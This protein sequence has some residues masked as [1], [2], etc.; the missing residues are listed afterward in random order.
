MIDPRPTPAGAGHGPSV[1]SNKGK[2]FDIG[3]DMCALLYVPV[4]TWSGLTEAALG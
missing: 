2:G 1:A 3:H 4:L